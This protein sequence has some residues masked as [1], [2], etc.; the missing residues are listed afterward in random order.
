MAYVL[1][2]LPTMPYLLPVVLTVLALI[3]LWLGLPRAHRYRRPG[4][5]RAGVMMTA[6]GLVGVW[7]LPAGVLIVV[8]N[9]ELEGLLF[10]LAVF[11]GMGVLGGGIEALRTAN[12]TPSGD[13]WDS[14]F[15]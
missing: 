9:T 15:R 7:L 4:R 1:S 3:V 6:L 5:W 8:D 14:I 11:C 13:Q 12:N 2:F 10:I